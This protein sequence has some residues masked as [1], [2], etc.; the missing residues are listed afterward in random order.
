MRDLKKVSSGSYQRQP[1]KYQDI[2]MQEP[3]TITNNGRERLV[4]MSI[5]E[6]RK[7]ESLVRRSLRIEELTDK[8]VQAIKDSEIPSEHSFE[9]KY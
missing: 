4:V 1:G 6:F 2:A 8:Q 9:M 5:D 7:M 3:I